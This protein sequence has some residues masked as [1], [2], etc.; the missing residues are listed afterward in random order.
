MNIL[1]NEVAYVDNML[2]NREVNQKE[3]N[4]EISLLVRYLVN[5]GETRSEILSFINS[6]MSDIIPKFSIE[7]WEP[8]IDKYIR[9]AKKR[10]ILELEYVPVTQ[11]EL[12]KI[13]KVNDKTKEKLL[14]TLLVLAKYNNLKSGIDHNNSWVNFDEKTIFKLARI[15]CPLRERDKLIH[16]LIVDGY[17]KNS[18]K[19]TSLNMQVLFVDNE[20]DPVLKIT[21]MR[22]L[23]FQ[24]EELLPNNKVRRCINCGKPYK[25]KKQSQR[26]GLCP[27]CNEVRYA[28]GKLFKV[29]QC[30]ICGAEFVCPSGDNRSYLCPEHQKEMTKQKKAAVMQKLRKNK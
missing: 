13:K 7:E 19:I 3:L 9:R 11:K 18:K 14:F 10:K 5:S 17:I 8:Y 28:N 4:V 25:L 16:E 23:G 30:K 20:S 27:I 21:D 12:D 22:E 29:K 1:L 26:A 24:Y 6:F 2:T 15:G